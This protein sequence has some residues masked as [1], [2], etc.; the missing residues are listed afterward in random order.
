MFQTDH[1]V[2]SRN[3]V[4]EG[5]R[6]LIESISF[7]RGGTMLDLGCGYGVVGIALAAAIPDWQVWMVDINAR[8]VELSRYNAKVN[9]VESRVHVLQSDGCS[10]LSSDLSFDAIALNPPIRA[11]KSVVFGLYQEAVERLKDG[12]TLYVVIQKKQGAASSEKR[13]LELGFEVSVVAKDKGYRVY[14]CKKKN[15]FN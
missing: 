13:L 12:G 11:G 3:E 7:Q 1:G 10:A 2:F 5:S 6:L 15:S 8:A 9:G 14:A 4:D